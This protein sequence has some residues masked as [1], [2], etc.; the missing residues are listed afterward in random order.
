[1]H[2]QTLKE[3]GK[4][5]TVNGKPE[6]MDIAIQLAAVD[7]PRRIVSETLTKRSFCCYKFYCLTF[8]L[9]NCKKNRNSNAIPVKI[10]CHCCDVG[11]A[12][13]TCDKKTYFSIFLILIILFALQQGYT[14]P[15]N[16]LF[17]IW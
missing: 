1:M 8:N 10:E 14:F 5:L 3:Y 6:P 12:G 11:H 13:L 15:M 7:F 9:C 2:Y 17:Y 16:D 4:I